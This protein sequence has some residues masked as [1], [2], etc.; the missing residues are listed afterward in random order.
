M[1]NPAGKSRRFL[2][3]HRPGQ[4]LLLANPWDEGAAKILASLGFQALATTSSGFAATLG[5]ADGSV[6]L[7]DAATE[8]R[9]KGTYG[10]HANTAAGRKAASAAFG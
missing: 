2:D 7:V 9:D 6:T 3:L 10:F 5:R 4:P 1:P 8:L